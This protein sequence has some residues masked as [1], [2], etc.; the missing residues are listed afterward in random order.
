MEPFP[1]TYQP[2]STF[3]SMNIRSRREISTRD[4][5]NVRQFEHW[6]TDAP[7]LQMDRP[8]LSGAKILS[9]MNPTNSRNLDGKL[10]QQNRPLQAGQ[11]SFTQ[12]PYFQGYAPEYDSRNAVRELRSAIYE[13]RFDKG[14]R[15]SKYLL[16]RTFTSQWL[17]PDYVGENNLDTLNSLVA[18]ESLKP[19]MD[20]IA[21]NFRS[22]SAKNP[23]KAT[24]V[25]RKKVEEEPKKKEEAKP[26][27][28]K[29][30]LTFEQTRL[31]YR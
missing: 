29:T 27:A 8:D 5:A 6:Q 13:D 31:A 15:E 17:A 14:V 26:I 4:A 7:Y 28:S 3:F 20:D 10:Y 21:N 1:A 11:D 19:Q 9:D 2:D 16:G 23:I 12:N 24:H 25:G 30:P 22:V 18:Y